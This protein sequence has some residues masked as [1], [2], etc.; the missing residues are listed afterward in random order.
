MG[1]DETGQSKVKVILISNMK[2]N[3]PVARTDIPEFIA[4]AN[5]Y[6]NG[7]NNNNGG[8]DL[9][10]ILSPTDQGYYEPETSQV[11]RL[12]LASE[13]GYGSLNN[14]VCVV[15]DKVNMVGAD[16]VPFW[17]WLQ[18]TCRTPAGMGRVEGNFEKF[19]LDGHTGV[20]LRRYPRKYNPTAIQQDIEAIIA[21]RSLP[22][23]DAQFREEWIRAAVE[24]EKSPYRFQKGFNDYDEV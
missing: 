3:D 9:A 2:G 20:P 8:G 15:T 24:A 1:N 17:R 16:A 13:Y 4:L 12:K 5:K 19:L 21:G 14:P 10:V 6:N 7:R 23:A 18:R 11:I 22:P